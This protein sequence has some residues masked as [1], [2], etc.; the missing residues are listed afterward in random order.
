MSETASDDPFFLGRFV[1]AQG[2]VYDQALSEMQNG[3][4]L[5]HWMWFIFPQLRGLGSTET[6]KYYAIGSLDEARAYL[7]DDVLGP[8][9]IACAEAC[10][11][12]EG[13]SAHE[14]FSSPDD[15]KLRSSATLFADVSPDNSVFHQILDKY[16]NGEPDSK[17]LSL[18]S[19]M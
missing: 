3:K 19:A 14:I 17:T 13:R 5:T 9:L 12:V 11:G 16:F 2:D 4:K 8:R 10:L 6:S 18:I 1:S 7:A 15:M